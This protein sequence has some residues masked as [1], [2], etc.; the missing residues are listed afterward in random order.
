MTMRDAVI[1]FPLLGDLTLD[2]P[3]AV[4]I[5]SFSIYLYGIIIACGLLLAI[6]YGVRHCD[7]MGLNSDTLYDLVIWAVICAIIGARAYYCIFNWSSYAADPMCIFA[8][9]DGGLAIYGGVIGAIVALYVRCRMKGWSIFPAL[10]IMGFGLLIGQSIGRWGNF[11]NREAYGYETDIF[12]RMG[13]TLGESTIYVHPTFL[14]ES[15]WNAAGFIAMHFYSKRH[16]KYRGQFFLM[17]V[18]WYGLGRTMIE[19]LRSDSLWLIPGVI[20]VSQLLAAVTCIAALALLIVNARRVK[21]GRAPAFG[22]RLDADDMII[23]GPAP[24][25]EETAETAEEDAVQP[26]EENVKRD[27]ENE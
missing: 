11:F 19:G 17:Y 4:S 9:R 15:L 16:H 2:P 12:C 21:A 25:T 1:S 23:M 7:R 6:I 5:G 20:R 22:R 26:E 18:A 10:D 8:I 13:L 27:P 3:Y 14:Y 24:E